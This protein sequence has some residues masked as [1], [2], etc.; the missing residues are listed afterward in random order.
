MYVEG[1]DV[2]IEDADG[3]VMEEIP[4]KTRKEREEEM[5]K[6]GKEFK[7]D[8]EHPATGYKN[9]RKKLGVWRHKDELDLQGNVEKKPKEPRHKRGPALA[10][11]FGNTVS[12]LELLFRAFAEHL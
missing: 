12:F 10:Y 1:D 8:I 2:I 9:L 5:K 3:E 7:D 4:T 6:M 11:Q